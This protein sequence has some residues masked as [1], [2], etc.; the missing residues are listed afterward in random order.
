MNAPALRADSCGICCG[1][2]W[3]W[4]CLRRWALMRKRWGKGVRIRQ[5]LTRL[6]ARHA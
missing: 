3:R 5:C 6:T 2:P 1:L 4:R